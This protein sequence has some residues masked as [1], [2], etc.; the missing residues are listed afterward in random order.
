[1]SRTPSSTGG[2]V[3]KSGPGLPSS[4][5]VAGLQEG[6]G[7]HGGVERGVGPQLVGQRLDAEF[8]GDLALGAALLLERQVQVFQLLLGRR[9][10]DGRAQLGGELALLVDGLEHGAAPVFEFAQVRKA[11]F[12]FAQLHVVEA[13]GD[14]LAIAGDE[15]NRGASV[16]QFDGGLHLMLADLDFGGELANDFLHA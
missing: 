14:L 4:S 1:M 3:E 10:F 11:C 7:F 15:W 9:E 5:V 2:T 12:Q 16:E 8:A 6:L 13:V